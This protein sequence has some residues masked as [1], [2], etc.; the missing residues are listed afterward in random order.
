MNRRKI[1]IF[2]ILL[3]LVTINSKVL[4]GPGVGGGTPQFNH[5][6]NGIHKDYIFQSPT[7]GN[8]EI[9][10]E[11]DVI[12]Y[13]LLGLTIRISKARN[14]LQNCPANNTIIK[15][16]CV[17]HKSSHMIRTFIHFGKS[18]ADNY[19]LEIEALPQRNIY[20]ENLHRQVVNSFSK[21]LFE[22]HKF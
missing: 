5:F 19:I 11:K 6:I 14:S 15:K 9:S 7:P 21:A 12:T 22:N 20:L 17:I 3:L 13:P 18:P 2:H 4:A 16:A 8:L 1:N 10:K